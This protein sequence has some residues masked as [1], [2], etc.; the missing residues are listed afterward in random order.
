MTSAGMGRIRQA[1]REVL[2]RLFNGNPFLIGVRRALFALPGMTPRTILHA[3]PPLRW[4]E[5]TAPMKRAVIGA[6]L[7]EGWADSEDAAAQ[8]VSK[9]AVVLGCTHDHDAVAPMAGVISPSMYVLRVEN[10][11]FG[12]VAYSNL[13]EG[14]GRVL[15]FGAL[16]ADVL[17]HLRWLNNTLGPILRQAVAQSGPISLKAIMVE[18]VRRGDECHNRHVAGNKLFIDYLRPQL[19]R[20]GLSDARAMKVLDFIDGNYYFFL[21]LSLASCKAIADA[22]HGVAYSTIVTAMSRNGRHTGVR[23]AGLGKT[24]FLATAPIPTGRFFA[25]YSEDDANPDMGDSTITETVGVGAFA[26]AAAPEIVGYLGGSADKAIGYNDQMYQI[27]AGE[28]PAFRLAQLGNRG[29]PTGIDV[30]KVRETGITPIINTGIAHRG[31]SAGQI[32]AGYT[33]AP[34]ECF[35]R[36]MDAFEEKYGRI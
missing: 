16:D 21:N 15:R 4:S 29:S 17:R 13:N 22:A 24:W 36:A 8:M 25:G 32:G 18:A 23:V 1:N 26:M 34:R 31:G 35:V 2:T 10:A 20:M 30:L 33:W 11:T 12:N 3:G 14:L 7:F 19:L 6:V 5:M 28:N 27:A 9:G